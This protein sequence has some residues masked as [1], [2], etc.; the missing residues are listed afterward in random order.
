MSDV[1]AA[2]YVASIIIIP[3]FRPVQIIMELQK[4]SIACTC[5]CVHVLS[6][7]FMYR[8]LNLLLHNRQLDNNTNEFIKKVIV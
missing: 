2:T 6:C 1:R 5:K 3:R 8:W 4:M 7:N